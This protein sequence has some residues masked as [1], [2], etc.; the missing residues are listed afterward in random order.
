[1]LR[2]PDGKHETPHPATL[3]E[4]PHPTTPQ[5]FNAHIHTPNIFLLLFRLF[6]QNVCK[7]HGTERHTLNPTPNTLHP[8]PSPKGL[9]LQGPG[10]GALLEL[11]R[12]RKLEAART[13]VA[14]AA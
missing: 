4:T 13:A 11:E 14:L 6:W 7:A 5:Y 2:R 3:D 8:R 9:H 1:M 10:H 12:G